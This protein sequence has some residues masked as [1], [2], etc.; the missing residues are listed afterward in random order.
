MTN[1]E[2]VE[3]IEGYLKGAVDAAPASM[4]MVRTKEE[5][6]GGGGCSK[7]RF[8]DDFTGQVQ[9]Y[10][11]YESSKVTPDVA[12]QYLDTVARVWEQQ[13][14]PVDR[15]KGHLGVR[16]D[17]GKFTL[18]GNSWPGASTV[19]ISGTSECIWIDGTPGPDDNP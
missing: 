9:A 14:G 10:V 17:D 5:P 3:H 8:Y 18:Y 13:Y 6:D 16:I 1:S 15:S 19:T 12:S 4:H 7:S 2:A 11:A